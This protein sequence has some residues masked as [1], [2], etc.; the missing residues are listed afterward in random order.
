MRYFEELVDQKVITND[1]AP[2][3]FIDTVLDAH[4]ARAR[5]AEQA[6]RAATKKGEEGDSKATPS[7]QLFARARTYS[8]AVVYFL[9]REK[10]HQFEG[11]LQELSKLPRDAELDPQAVIVAFCKGYGIDT[12]GLSAAS[13]D[14]RRFLG[15]GLEWYNFMSRQMS[16]SRSLKIDNLAIT[17][18]APGAPGA[19]EGGIPGFPGFPGGPGGPGG[20]FP[21]G[22]GGPPGFPGGPGGGSPGG[23]S[24]G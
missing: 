17:P 23:G 11:F 1:N 3:V 6:E 10:F 5:K 24:P 15:V 22:P 13:P 19:G 12:S 16:P 20:G 18:G 14:I 21:G 2:D 7:E 4:F 8:W 9:A